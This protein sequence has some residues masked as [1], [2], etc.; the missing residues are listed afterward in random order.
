MW[1]TQGS[2]G[3]EEFPRFQ[4]KREEDRACCLPFSAAVAAS[5]QSAPIL[6]SADVRDSQRSVCTLAKKLWPSVKR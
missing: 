3:H 2:C 6:G 1:G 4:G 5:G